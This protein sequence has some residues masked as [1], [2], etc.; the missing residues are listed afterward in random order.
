MTT[1][2]YT[3]GRNMLTITLEG[4]E[5]SDWTAFHKAIAQHGGKGIL[6]NLLPTAPEQAQ[7]LVLGAFADDPEW[8]VFLQAIA[9]ERAKANARETE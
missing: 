1:K 3:L 2:D 7:A 5:E 8:D 6:P 9:Q 4:E